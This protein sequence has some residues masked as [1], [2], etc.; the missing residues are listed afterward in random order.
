MRCEDFLSL[1]AVTMVVIIVVIL[2][3]MMM[4]ILMLVVLV[5]FTMECG[6]RGRLGRSVGMFLRRGA[7]SSS[8]RT[9]D[10]LCLRDDQLI[11]R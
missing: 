3:L 7:V 8:V 9:T 6:G 11:Q 1:V 4:A 10:N 2:L 5:M